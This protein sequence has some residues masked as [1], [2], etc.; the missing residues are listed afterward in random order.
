MAWLK[1]GGR[2]RLVEERVM[3]MTKMQ[4]A[5]FVSTMNLLFDH[6]GSLL[7]EQWV[8]TSLSVHVVE[9]HLFYYTQELF[10]CLYK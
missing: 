9:S 1:D 7:A 4:R 6:V 2:G 10:S 3:V 8:L 5:K